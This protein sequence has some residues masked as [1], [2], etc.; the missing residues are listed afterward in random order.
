MHFTR[1]SIS[2][3]LDEAGKNLLERFLLLRDSLYK[4]DYYFYPESEREREIL[5]TYAQRTD[6]H[7]QLV[8]G[9][10][11]KGFDRARILVGSCEHYS[12]PFF[13]FFECPNEQ[14]WFQGL[15]EEAENIAQELGGTELRGPINLNPFHDWMFLLQKDAPERWMGDPY[16]FTYY[17]ELFYQNNWEVFAEATSGIVSDKEHQKLMNMYSE[18]FRRFYQ[19]GFRIK[20][21]EEVSLDTIYPQLL[22]IIHQAFDS[23]HHYFAPVTLHQLQ[24]K[25][26]TALRLSDDPYSLLL[27]YRQGELKGFFFSLWNPIDY[28]CNPDGKKPTP[29]ESERSRLKFA[30]NIAALTPEIQGSSAYKALLILQSEHTYNYYGHPVA[31][32]RTNVEHPATSKLLRQGD[33][34]HKYVA[35]RKRI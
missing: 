19:E 16:H 27:V 12:W 33:I 20:T 13:G 9:T 35:F 11:N 18:T 2:G 4:Q 26:L 21:M 5:T 14:R 23:K 7:F 6:Y 24:E 25:T 32:G 17:P 3:E 29:P 15:L 10:D 22:E 30:V 31:W 34:T 28:L 1:F 8:I